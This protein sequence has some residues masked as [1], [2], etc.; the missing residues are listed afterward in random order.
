MLIK[1]ILS[2]K[3][4]KVINLLHSIYYGHH[5]AYKKKDINCCLKI[6]LLDTTKQS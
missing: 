4:C 2:K 1:E 3:R 5:S 6:S